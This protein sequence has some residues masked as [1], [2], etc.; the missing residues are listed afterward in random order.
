MRNAAR[1]WSVVALKCW[2][3]MHMM[4]SIA[5][6]VDCRQWAGEA[7]FGFYREAVI[8]CSRGLQAWAVIFYRFAII[9]N[10]LASLFFTQS[11]MGAQTSVDSPLSTQE[12]TIQPESIVS[13]YP[14]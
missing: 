10:I 6:S 2:Q 12:T 4:N 11:A 9:G 1:R 13:G 14:F 3:K 5:K 8:Q 7:Y